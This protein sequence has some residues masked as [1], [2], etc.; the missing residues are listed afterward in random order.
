MEWVWHLS[1]LTHGYYPSQNTQTQCQGDAGPPD[2][3]E[4]GQPHSKQYI[5]SQNM[6]PQELATWDC[7]ELGHC[8]DQPF[9]A[10]CGIDLLKN[11]PIRG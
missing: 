11:S 4:R 1:H 7:I 8:H 5:S 2:A 6:F 3:V 9:Y 10:G